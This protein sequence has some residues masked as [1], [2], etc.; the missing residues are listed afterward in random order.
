MRDRKR[1]ALCYHC[2]REVSSCCCCSRKSAAVAVGCWC[3]TRCSATWYW[4]T[5]D[6]CVVGNSRS[7]GEFDA[8]PGYSSPSQS[9][10]TAAFRRRFRLSYAASALAYRQSAGSC[11]AFAALCRDSYR[12]VVCRSA[13]DLGAGG[14]QAGPFFLAILMV[15]REPPSGGVSLRSGILCGCGSVCCHIE[16]RPDTP[17]CGVEFSEGCCDAGVRELRCALVSAKYGSRNVADIKP[18]S[19]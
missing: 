5:G 2:A 9:S 16:H 12:G 4:W 10:A 11:L 6:H 14:S 18:S 3:A 8:R 7:A 13:R 15:A 17:Q 1:P 19:G